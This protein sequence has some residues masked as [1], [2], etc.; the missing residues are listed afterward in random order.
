VEK[1]IYDFLLSHFTVVVVDLKQN[2]WNLDDL[3]FNYDFTIVSRGREGITQ[4][5]YAYSG[6]VR[7]IE[8]N[9]TEMTLNLIPEMLDGYIKVKAAY[10]TVKSMRYVEEF[11]DLALEYY[12]KITKI[13]EKYN[14]LF[15]S[16]EYKKFKEQVEKIYLLLKKKEKCYNLDIEEY[17]FCVDEAFDQADVD[18]VVNE[19]KKVLDTYRLE[20]R[21]ITTR[22]P[23]TQSPIGFTEEPFVWTWSYED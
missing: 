1:K 3:S 2:E 11:G 5:E 16:L 23:E 19:L 4:F 6:L 17:R 8:Q 7:D 21:Y 15:E 22:D 14:D 13:I 20:P 9:V 18:A 10:E 12:E